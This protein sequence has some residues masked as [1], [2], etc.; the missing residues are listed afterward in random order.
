MFSESE[1]ALVQVKGS[2]RSLLQE[3]ENLGSLCLLNPTKLFTLALS[4]GLTP[5]FSYGI[6]ISSRDLVRIT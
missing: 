4:V 5:L 3:M 6:Q 1:S 2:Q